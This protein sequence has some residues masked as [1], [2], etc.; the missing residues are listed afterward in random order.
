INI[1]NYSNTGLSANTTYY[2][3]VRATN[4]LGAS[5]N[6]AQASA[7]TLSA[8]VPVITMEPQSQTVSPNSNATFSVTVSGMSPFFYQWHFNG[9]NISLATDSSYTRT[10]AQ[11]SDQGGYSVVVTNSF[12]SV[13]SSAATLT[14]VSSPIITT[15]PTN[16]TVA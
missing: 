14:V 10:N 6:S 2:Y 5:A 9:T 12:G 13:T 3:V 4:F 1:T 11:S 16:L 15:Q 7:T 8:T